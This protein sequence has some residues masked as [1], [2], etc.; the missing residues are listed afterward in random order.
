MIAAGE[1]VALEVRPQPV[2]DHGDVALVH[3]VYQVVHLLLCQKLRLV[4]DDAGVA[5]QFFIRHGLHLVEIDAGVLQADAGVHHVVAVPAVQPWLDHQ[6]LLS[7]FL[8]V[9]PRHQRV[10]GFA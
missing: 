6:R 2:A 10:G 7:P 9:E 3:Q 5:L 4:D 1:Q 8:V